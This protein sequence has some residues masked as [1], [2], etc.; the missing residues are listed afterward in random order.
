M[1]KK[2]VGI[3]L[4]MLMT[5]ATISAVAV[6]TNEGTNGRSPPPEIVGSWYSWK[7]DKTS[8]VPTYAEFAKEFDPSFTGDPHTVVLATGYM[9]VPVDG[10]GVETRINSVTKLTCTFSKSM[11]P[12]T[13]DTNS[14]CVCGNNGGPYN[15]TSIL[16]ENGTNGDYTELTMFFDANQLPN[17]HALLSLPDRYVACISTS[18]EDMTG[19]ALSGDRDVEFICQFGNVWPTG[20]SKLKTNSKDRAEVIKHELLTFADPLKVANFD[21]WNTG[22][23]DGK[24]NSK[25]RAEVIK[26]ESLT[27]AVSTTVPT[28]PC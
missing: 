17:G 4:C 5:V 2:I 19:V 20:P 26:T 24:I 3:L 21:V 8:T 1:N 18:V 25:D 7:T 15:P 16:L 14:I 6:T 9:T 22:P 13:I 28:C 27:V 11:N 23:S 10:I 12:A